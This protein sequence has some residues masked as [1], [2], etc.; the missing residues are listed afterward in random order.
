M[1][2]KPWPATGVVRRIALLRIHSLTAP[3]AVWA[4]IQSGNRQAAASTRSFSM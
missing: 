2:S 1:S 3:G 4:A